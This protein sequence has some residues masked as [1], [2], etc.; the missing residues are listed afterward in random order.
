M[1]KHQPS[2]E[3]FCSGMSSTTDSDRNLPSSC[4]SVTSSCPTPCPPFSRPSGSGSATAAPSNN[5][6]GHVTHVPRTTETELV[7]V[8]ISQILQSVLS[9]V[10]RTTK[11]S[12]PFSRRSTR[13]SASNK[14]KFQERN[15]VPARTFVSFPGRSE[16]ESKLFSMTNYGQIIRAWQP[17][18]TNIIPTA[19]VLSILQLSYHALLSGTFITKRYASPRGK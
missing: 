15:P 6:S 3:G 8:K 17:R 10:N 5:I 9:N 13:T 2:I 11:L 12:I 1:A 7:I 14:Q 16:A 19:Q 4:S 18:R